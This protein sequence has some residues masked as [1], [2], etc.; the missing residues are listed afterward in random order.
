MPNT[1]AARHQLLGRLEQAVMDFI[2][3]HAPATA[4]ACREA[5][6]DS[7]PMKD[8]TV[9]TVLRRLESK[10]YLAHSVEGRTF[11]YRPAE[12]RENVAARAV[13][14]I[15]DRFCGGSAEQLLLGMVDNHVLD[16]AQIERLAAKIKLQRKRGGK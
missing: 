7:W 1:K 15:I 3:S 16:R 9:R 4:E 13:K 12:R 6:A 5:L 8:S 2:W 10:G 14:H 11:V